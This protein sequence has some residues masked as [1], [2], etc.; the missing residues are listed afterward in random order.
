MHEYL[1]KE[2]EIL[3]RFSL[4]LDFAKNYQDL[5]IKSPRWYNVHQTFLLAISHLDFSR[6]SRTI[7]LDNLEIFADPLLERVFFI[8]A[9]NILAHGKNA[10][11]LTIWYEET[12]DHLLL[13]FEDNGPG[14]PDIGKEKIF[15]RSV[16]S[17]NGIGLFFAREILEITGITI[18]ETGICGKGARFE[19]SIPGGSFRFPGKTA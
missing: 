18:R 12:A 1:E 8:L 17:Q 11:R 19:I 14:I 3:R 9:D 2:V 7:T 4:S 10:T 16:S 6:I 5:G 13:I 15:Q